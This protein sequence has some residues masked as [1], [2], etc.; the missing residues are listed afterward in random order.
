[1]SN[2]ELSSIVIPHFLLKRTDQKF[3]EI[4]EKY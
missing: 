2:S 3:I 4:Y 1:M